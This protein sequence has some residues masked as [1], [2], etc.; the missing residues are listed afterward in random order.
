MRGWCSDGPPSNPPG[1]RVSLSSDR[2][3]QVA[4]EHLERLAVTRQFGTVIADNQRRLAFD[5]HD[6]IERIENACA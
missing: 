6:G 5:R 1:G 3:R 4:R 2:G